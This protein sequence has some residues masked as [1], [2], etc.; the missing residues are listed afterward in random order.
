MKSTTGARQDKRVWHVRGK[1]LMR[2]ALPVAR[3]SVDATSASM[4]HLYQCGFMHSPVFVPSQT[5]L[6]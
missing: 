5:G 2:L 6:P 1:P 3:R 4:R